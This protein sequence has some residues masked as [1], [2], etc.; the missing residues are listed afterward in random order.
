MAGLNYLD[1]NNWRYENF[2]TADLLSVSGTTLT[3]LPATQ[4]KTGSAFYQ[5]TRAKCFDLPATNEIWI[6]FDMYLSSSHR[7]RVY[8]TGTAGECG[9]IFL[10]NA[11]NSIDFYSNGIYFKELNYIYEKNTLQTVLLHMVSDS[12][13]GIVEA[14]VDGDFIYRYTGNVNQGSDFADIYLQ[15]DGS[16]TFFSNVIISNTQIALDEVVAELRPI[17]NIAIKPEIYISWIPTGQ[18][19]LKPQ[20][21]AS[22]IPKPEKATADLFRIVTNSESISAD[23]LRKVTKSENNPADLLRKLTY[24]DTFPA[25]T[26]RKVYQHEITSGDT[27][28]HVVQSNIAAADSFR[29]V[30]KTEIATADTSR[31]MGITI[32][33]ADIQ[34]NV[35]VST[36]ATFDTCRK[37]GETNIFPADTYLKTARTD[38]ARADSFREVIVTTVATADALRKIGVIESFSGDTSRTLGTTETSQADT[39]R[40]VTATE[41]AI[42]DLIRALREVA[43]YD[44]FR[45]VTQK[46]KAIASTVIRVPHVWNYFIKLRTSKKLLADTPS[47]VNTF[48]SYGITAVNITLSERT[49]SDNF[50]FQTAKPININDAVQGSLLNYHFNFLVEEITQTELIR[51]VKGRYNQDDLLYTWFLLETPTYTFSNGQTLEMP[52]GHIEKSRDSDGNKTIIGVYPKA[53]EIISKVAAYFGLAADIHIDDFT[54]SNLQGDEK[55]T[56]FDLL[57]SVFSWTSRVPQRQIN[58]FIRGNTLHCIQR[59]KET[60]IFDISDLQHSR[61]TVNKKF[62]RVLCHNPNNNNNNNNNNDDDDNEGY[63]F[64]GHIYYSKS[65]IAPFQ[66]SVHMSYTYS[67]GLLV[68]ET[69]STTTEMFANSEGEIVT[70]SNN[71]TTTYSYKSYGKE[72]YIS[73]KRQNTT[74]KEQN[75]NTLETNTTEQEIKTTYGYST[76]FNA[77]SQEHE[78]YLFHEC[79]QTTKTEYQS[80]SKEREITKEIRD[81]YHAPVGNGWYAQTVYLNGILQGAN[82]SQGKPG[83]SVSPYTVKQMQNTFR[84]YVIIQNPTANNENDGLSNIIDD[85]FPIRDADIKKE[86]NNA[87][88]W[89]HRKVQETVDVDLISKVNNGIPEINHIVDFTE[90]VKL[91]GNEYFLVSNNISFTPRKLIQKLQ[92]I[93]W[94]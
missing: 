53:I 83:N 94:Y 65:G 79:E 6:K 32:A 45:K 54:P 42:A 69:L 26:K 39:Y 71:S 23:S 68:Q 29:Q 7:C 73:S 12:S 86:L 89:L 41:I 47:L 60:S 30:K 38:I 88:R 13:A 18:V 22:Y 33:D 90:R 36:S 80:G 15:S 50:T 55:I 75:M 17:Y 48:K 43:S 82:L 9:M 66:S 1:N 40:Q 14:W 31:K 56:Y 77:Q 93:R 3:N 62:N 84:H 52:G 10:A 27:F 87:L 74:V 28:R 85:S 35:I 63:K 2:G 81:T 72:S 20:I 49:L 59:G 8:N 21:Y 11:I 25:D 24:S 4:S 37:I 70:L 64:S 76:D 5:T 16:G 78:I 46:E 91:D 19:Y 34:R 44:I 51:E 92:L 67:K 58:L 57:N 61:P